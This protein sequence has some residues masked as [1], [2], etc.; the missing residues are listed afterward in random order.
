MP[1]QSAVLIALLI[2]I[3]RGDPPPLPSPP[4]A[5]PLPPAAAAP[6]IPQA[7]PLL[8]PSPPLV[9]PASLPSPAAAAPGNPQL[10]DCHIQI[11]FTQPVGPN[12]QTSKSK[13]PN[14]NWPNSEPTISWS[15]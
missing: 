15:S 4:P 12:I 6:Q 7:S 8:P 2:V 5:A 1:S 10:V 11:S 9:P 14:P 3:V 13:Y